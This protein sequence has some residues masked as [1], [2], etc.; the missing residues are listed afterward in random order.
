MTMNCCQT[1]L[2]N[3]PPWQGGGASGPQGSPATVA[4]AL[5]LSLLLGCGA[6][7]S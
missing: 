2:C 1:A 7:G 3:S 4:A 5:L 6:V